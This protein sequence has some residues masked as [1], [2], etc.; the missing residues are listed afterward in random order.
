V[1]GAGAVVRGDVPAKAIAVGMPAKVVG[2][3]ASSELA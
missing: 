1:I 3:R 2:T